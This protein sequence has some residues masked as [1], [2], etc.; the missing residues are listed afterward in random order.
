M[1]SQEWEQRQ[2]EGERQANAHVVVYPR[3][4]IPDWK[5]AIN[6]GIFQI[7]PNTSGTWGIYLT[8]N[9]EN[10]EP[11]M[12]IFGNYDTEEEAQVGWGQLD[13]VIQILRKRPC[14]LQGFQQYMS[15]LSAY[16][17]TDILEHLE[18]IERNKGGEYQ[19]IP[20]E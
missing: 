13:I 14:D 12:H 5:R 16:V 2:I 15:Y 6:K 3:C 1:N 18:L 19:L 20:Y 7:K 10:L 17:I 11:S 4:E 8:P 9:W